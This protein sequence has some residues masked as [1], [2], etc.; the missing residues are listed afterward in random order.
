MHDKSFDVRQSI[1]SA[2]HKG[3][4][5]QSEA[6]KMLDSGINGILSD[7]ENFCWK[8]LGFTNG[9]LEFCGKE[10]QFPP[11][12]RKDW[13]TIESALFRAC[14]ILINTIENNQIAEEIDHLKT[15]IMRFA[16]LCWAGDEYEMQNKNRVSGELAIIIQ[17]IRR[18]YR[19][20]AYHSASSL[21][22]DLS[23]SPE[24]LKISLELRKD[25][26]YMY[27][28]SFVSRFQ[29]GGNFY[30]CGPLLIIY[31]QR[32]GENLRFAGVCSQN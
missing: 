28:F 19:N 10:S 17:K 20:L 27:H 32:I 18:Q 7:V 5:R 12:E 22:Q 30:R 8:M 13:G 26:E 23:I 11:N 25:I 4:I 14:D 29:G 9:I 6:V 15:E 31:C 21:N 3:G 16:Q 2:R 1:D 24:K